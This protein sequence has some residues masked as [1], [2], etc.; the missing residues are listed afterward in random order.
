MDIDQNANAEL[1][2]KV[3][4]TRIR[5][6]PL[7]A[8]AAFVGLS[9]AP[10]DALAA[11]T[12][13][14]FREEYEDIVCSLL[15]EC[16]GISCDDNSVSYED[17]DECEY[18]SRAAKDC[19]DGL[20]SLDCD[21]WSDG[22][23]PSACEWV[24]DCPDWF[25]DSEIDAA[26]EELIDEVG[27]VSA[28]VTGEREILCDEVD[29]DVDRDPTEHTDP[30]VQ[31]KQG[32][33]DHTE[34]FSLAAAAI[35]L[36]TEQINNAFG[37]TYYPCGL[38]LNGLTLCAQGAARWEAGRYVIITNALE[39]NVPLAD[40]THYY[41]YGFVFDSDGDASN[42]YVPPPAF[43]KDFFRDTDRWYD[44][45]YDPAS[46]WTL[47]VTD[48][49]NGDLVPAQSTARV[50]IASNTMTL[51]VPREELSAQALEYR[52]TAFRHLGDFGLNPPNDWSGDVE[53]P[54]DQA[55]RTVKELPDDPGSDGADAGTSGSGPGPQSQDDGGGGCSIGLASPP[56][57]STTRT[58]LLTFLVALLIRRARRRS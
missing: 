30:S 58:F 22:G 3:S 12:E 23:F 14:N 11:F 6:V 32:A 16:A 24:Y 1:R 29:T 52:V 18:D 45:S 5:L 27:D 38:G 37:N 7:V 43:A 56:P 20:E 49:R 47:K 34:V 15:Q 36:I 39:G 28:A 51:V 33:G 2:P 42:N 35:G 17:L 44:A 10:D 9:A 19:A 4:S 26:D 13:D 31:D 40:P 21:A 8:M 25:E 54:V 46:G 50:I 48:A 55:L 41:Q 57:G 53:P